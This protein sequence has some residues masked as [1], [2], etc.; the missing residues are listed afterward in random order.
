MVVVKQKV[1]CLRADVKRSKPGNSSAS[2]KA[3]IHREEKR[4]HKK[5]SRPSNSYYSE[6]SESTKHNTSDSDFS[7]Y[8]SVS[9]TDIDSVPIMMYWIR[10]SIF[11]GG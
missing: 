3:K 2:Y 4:D 7:S 10:L 1:A 6:I 5:H 11:L 9:R 8:K